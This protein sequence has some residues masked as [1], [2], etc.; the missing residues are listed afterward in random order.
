MVSSWLAERIAAMDRAP[1]ELS[2]ALAAN[3]P[4]PRAA[5]EVAQLRRDLAE[6]NERQAIQDNRLLV[7]DRELQL[8]RHSHEQLVSTLDAASDG[9]LTL[10][11]SDNSLYYNIRFVELWGI[12]EEQLDALDDA[13]LVAFQAARV[14]NPEALLSSI[15]QRRAN[16]DTEDYC[17]I[18]LLDGRV[19]E[20]HVLPQRLHGRCVGSVITYRDITDR[21]R[22][23]EKMMFNHL[24]LENSP[25]M[26]WI[27]RD[28][29][30]LVYANPAFCRSLGFQPEEMLGMKIS[31]YDAQSRQENLADLEENLQKAK[32][33][34]SFDSRHR[35]KDGSLC[36]VRLW[37]FKAESAKKSIYVIT[38][39]D[40]T[41][42][43]R[44][45]QDKK[46]Q[47]AMV[48]S[49]INSMPDPVFY[50]DPEGRYLGC[51]EA[52]TTMSGR[53]M[54]EIVG[55]T[56]FDLFPAQEAESI[57]ARDKATLFSL[58]RRCSENWITY[59]NGRRVLFETQVSPLWDENAEPRGVLGICRNITE[60][61]LA[62]EDIRRSKEL[63]EEATRMKSDFLANMSHEIRTPMN[64]IIGL[65]H[66]VLKTD[67]APRQRDYITKVQTSG[68]H[69]LGVINDILDFSKVEAG[70][71][72]LEQADF[73]LEKLLDNMSSL[74]GEKSHEKGLELVFEVA[75]DVPTCLVGD[76][77]RLG[78]I[79]LNY[80]NNAV[81][82][83]E[84][85][86]IVVS[87]R[88]SERTETDVLL[89]FRVRDSGI[90]L[91]P[92]QMERLFQSFSQADTSTTRKFGG[93]GLGLAISKKL[94]ELMGGE[95]GVES[96]YGKGSSFWFSARLGIGTARARELLPNPDLRG[97]RALVVDDNQYARA[98]MVD[99]L[100][101]MTF[102]TV[103]VPSGADAVEEVRRA[104][105]RGAPYDVIY[106]D[107]RM[108]GMD[109]M[110]TAR[111]IK[112]M[113]LASPPLFLMVTAYG[114][115]EL[116]REAGAI[117]IDSVLVK[118][119][120]ASVLFDTTMGALGGRRDGVAAGSSE[121]GPADGRLAA[122]RGAR[123]LLVED[124]DI[125]QLVAR[126]LLEDL[127]LV[128]EVADNGQIALDMVQQAPYDLVF[129]DMQMPVMDGVTATRE[130]RRIDRL[131]ALPIAAMTA[132]A[133]E[134]DRRKCLESGMNDFLVKPIDPQQLRTLLVR[135][136]RPM[137]SREAAATVPA[138]LEPTPS[139]VPVAPAPVAAAR[140]GLDGLPQG[141]DGLDT[142][143]GLSRMAG[144][145]T[146]YL[147]M[148]KRYVAGQKPLGGELRTALGAADLATAER[149]A[150]TCRGVSGNVGATLVQ[151]RAE[152]LELA[153]REGAPAAQ[154]EQHLAQ[155]EA[156]L[157]ALVQALEEA[158][159]A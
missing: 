84:K 59:P 78:Q 55:M 24:V 29:G 76:S 87:V 8:L 39:R 41:A 117:G 33:P 53:P 152:A 124:N 77:L 148:L 150:H 16:P 30:T 118:P 142:K 154:V 125:N 143:L 138:A 157:A 99:M 32:G 156:P 20:R 14:K 12:P 7:R 40:V 71:L 82:F 27:D 31:E 144:K 98:V 100:E 21:M 34:V 86:E 68:Q 88:A 136:I 115:E 65:S 54:S 52:Y 131:E 127:G 28:T 80:A 81:K 15:A 159:L 3:D 106:L 101:G 123:V 139:A 102:A 49:L 90:G 105:A 137:A 113:G 63:A 75:P 25:P 64:A 70:K 69:L 91:A 134:Q 133:M 66:L 62:E 89:N 58:Q 107:W 50:K 9:I 130:I 85:G 19:L 37:A 47:Q 72:D 2:N 56:C 110:E 126:E 135:W 116:L 6:A 4:A 42:Q 141:I 149:L 67:L 83:T 44:A 13:A 26:Y 121:S 61:K 93:T 146:L 18:E 97:R 92:E 95:V 51:N 151:A 17:V 108:P 140:L 111:R 38:A 128:V 114:N 74:I 120:N 132:N 119:V 79:L 48:L 5:D 122:L 60:R 94:A 36:D 109:G 104:A 73:Q 35:R 10:R 43:K 153:L 158:Q 46:R 45:E 23:E 96:E 112:A 11:Y 155:L 145:K 103:Q 129:M 147:A 1:T 22:Y 57:H